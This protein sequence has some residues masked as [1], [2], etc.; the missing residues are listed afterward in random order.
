M[1]TKLSIKNF[2]LIDDI[3]IEFSSGLTTITGETGAGKSILLGALALVLGKRADLNSVREPLKKCIVEA[4]FNL[5]DI[6]FEQIF[7]KLELDFDT[8]TIIRRELLP[9]GKSRAF[10][11]DTPVVLSKLQDLS[12]YLIDIHSQH[13]SLNMFSETYQLEVLD[14]LAGNS[15]LLSKYS[16]LL[17]EYQ[18]V[19]ES[20]THLYY[21]KESASK[22]LDYNTFLLQELEE[23]KLETLD[24]E[25]LEETYRKLNNSEVIQE[26]LSQVVGL[27]D[28]E[29]IGALTTLKEVRLQL[30]KLQ[31]LS[32]DFED[33]W[34]RINSS[35]IELEDITEEII[36]ATDNL[37]AN[38]LL[39]VEINEKLQ[40]LYKL[41]QK[42]NLSSVS[43][44]LKFKEELASKLETTFH[45]DEEISRLEKLQEQLKKTLLDLS[46]QLHN[47]R[48]SVVPTLTNKLK[49]LLTELGMPNADFKFELY[50]VPTFRKN[51]TDNIQLLFTANKGLNFGALKKV[52]SGG[53]LSRIMLSIKAVIAQYK[54]LPTAIF[55]E[56]DAGISGEVAYKMASILKEMSLTMQMISIT[57][58]PQ[59]A[60]VGNQHIKIYK[61]DVNEVTVTQI[62]KLTQEERVIEIAEII[63]GKNKSTSAINQAKEL[64][65]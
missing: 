2:A 16:E 28:D 13:E 11:N 18:D 64:L 1:I 30:N 56:I 21:K 39:L 53:E 12:P 31:N 8:H 22:E 42:H 45:L 60:A 7:R 19:S 41:Q 38:P 33:I 15:M 14:I 52:A 47:K 36:K 3:Q 6:T 4:E 26:T 34:N 55:D 61:K 63:G 27:L 9:S 25:I 17:S 44:L 5:E 54:Q 65:N 59:V 10:V 32:S 57:H 29:Q 35:I 49:E 51:G 23:T 20:I 40:N 24:Q 50:P 62:K 58:L 37:E 48:I 43:E 46:K